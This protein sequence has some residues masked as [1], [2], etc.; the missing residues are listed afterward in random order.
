MLEFAEMM[1]ELVLD[2]CLHHLLR[3]Y[4]GGIGPH[5]PLV[6]VPD[7]FRML[8]GQHLQQACRDHGEIDKDLDRIHRISD[9]ALHCFRHIPQILKGERLT[10]GDLPR[11]CPEMIAKSPDEWKAG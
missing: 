11:L 6:A 7:H 8:N 10:W 4:H 5:P 1:I 3:W 9:E 2:Y